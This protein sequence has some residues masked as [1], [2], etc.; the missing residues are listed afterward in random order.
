MSNEFRR[1]RRRKA[2][3]T[4]LVTDAMSE[5]VVGQIGN[6]SESGMLLIASETLVDDALYQLQFVLPDQK[7]K[8]TSVEV[9]AHLLWID[10][11]SA[12][13]QAWIGFRFIAVSA[14]YMERV[15]HWIEMPGGQYE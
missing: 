10:R 3:N 7:G 13:G 6:L 15:R 9:G 11:A 8:S 1:A 14:Q 4:I 5:R 2:S 12:P